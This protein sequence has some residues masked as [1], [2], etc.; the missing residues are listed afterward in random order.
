MEKI[1]DYCRQDRI[2]Y[3]YKI[4][5]F[6]IPKIITLPKG[7]FIFIGSLW[8]NGIRISSLSLES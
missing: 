4:A 5:A 6:R 7:T 2:I 1:S 3:V 8:M